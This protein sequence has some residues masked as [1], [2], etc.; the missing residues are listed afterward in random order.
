MENKT[1]TGE[2]TKEIFERGTLSADIRVPA[3]HSFHKTMSR[4]NIDP[5]PSLGTWGICAFLS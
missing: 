1:K 3:E 2:R 4:I 5:S